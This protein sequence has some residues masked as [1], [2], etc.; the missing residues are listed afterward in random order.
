MTKR[1]DGDAPSGASADNELAVWMSLGACMG[2]SIGVL[3]DNV[4]IGIALGMGF[5]VAIGV[6]R[7]R[8][9]QQRDEAAGDD[10]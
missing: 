5:G 6:A 10:L 8:A 7:R 9:H 1:G 4:G 2:I 3:A